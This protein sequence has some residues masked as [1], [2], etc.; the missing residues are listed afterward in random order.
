MGKTFS[1]ERSLGAVVIRKNPKLSES[2][3]VRY[4]DQG[5]IFMAAY[6]ADLFLFSLI[7][8]M[9]FAFLLPSRGHGTLEE[10][11]FAIL[12]VSIILFV[13]AFV[14]LMQLCVSKPSDDS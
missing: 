4:G 2:T 9:G 1:F 14:R 5:L 13:L 6:R 11:G 8:V 7:F 3:R 10:V 12:A